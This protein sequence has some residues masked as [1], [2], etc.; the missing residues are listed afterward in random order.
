MDKL[1][2]EKNSHF[3]RP[4]MPV[5]SSASCVSKSHTLMVCKVLPPVWCATAT[6]QLYLRLLDSFLKDNS[7]RG[8][9]F[10]I[11]AIRELVTL[12]TPQKPN[13]L[14]LKLCASIRTFYPLIMQKQPFLEYNFA[15]EVLQGHWQSMSSSPPAQDWGVPPLSLNFLC[16]TPSMIAFLRAGEEPRVQVPLL[17]SGCGRSLHSSISTDVSLLSCCSSQGGACHA[18]SFSGWHLSCSI[19][20]GMSAAE[21]CG[22]LVVVSGTTCS[23][24][25]CCLC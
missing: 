7:D 5:T 1:R 6:T 15:L 9:F 12:A 16:R 13:F 17:L 18:S 11:S 10:T 8:Q 21:A 22:L 23:A 2:E 4:W 20:S 14:H 19:T 3:C 24:R 25:K